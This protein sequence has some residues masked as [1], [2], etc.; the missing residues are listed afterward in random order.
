MN[1]DSTPN[2]AEDLPPAENISP[3][4]PAPAPLPQHA[5]LSPAQKRLQ[6]QTRKKLEFI[7]N[8]MQNLD[9]LIYVELCILY[10]MEYALQSIKD[11]YRC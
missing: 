10:Y 1:N 9:V 6:T 5:A 8:L 2:P 3:I 7:D 11:F 4:D